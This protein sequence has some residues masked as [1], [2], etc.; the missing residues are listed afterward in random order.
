MGNQG[1]AFYF[2]NYKEVSK[3]RRCFTPRG[4]VIKKWQRCPG[5]KKHTQHWN[6]YPLFSTHYTYIQTCM[7]VQVGT[8]ICAQS[9]GKA[10]HESVPGFSSLFPVDET[11][12]R[13]NSPRGLSRKNKAARLSQHDR[14]S[15]LHWSLNFSWLH[16]EISFWHLLVVGRSFHSFCPIWS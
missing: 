9:W 13:A 10:T 4:G 6:T 7:Q 3:P 12:E 11:D 5:I 16:Y 8:H 15:A 1:Q 14:V 2:Q